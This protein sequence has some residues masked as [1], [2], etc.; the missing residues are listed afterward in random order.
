MR[1][2]P[3]RAEPGAQ[4]MRR[5][6]TQPNLQTM[7]TELV[8]TRPPKTN[9]SAAVGL[10]PQLHGPLAAGTDLRIAE[11]DGADTTEVFGRLGPPFTLDLEGGHLQIRN[12][13]ESPAVHLS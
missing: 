12:T 5:E 13:R 8:P 4:E 6:R 11:R 9:R 1:I 2:L 7:A 10:H 3:R